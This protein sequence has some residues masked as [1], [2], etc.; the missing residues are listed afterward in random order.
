[1]VPE[2]AMTPN[3]VPRGIAVLDHRVIEITPMAITEAA[4]V[5]VMAPQ[6]GAHEDHRV[7]HAPRT[8][9]N[10]CPIESSRSSARPQRSRIA[11]MK[12]KNGIASSRSLEM[13]PNSW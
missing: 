6:N 3:R 13:T 9:P 1:M 5:P 7:G 8:G 10:S 2:A 11:P 4:T 12:V